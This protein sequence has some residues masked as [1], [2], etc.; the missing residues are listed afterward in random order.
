MQGVALD[1]PLTLLLRLTTDRG[2][3]VSPHLTAPLL[4]AA[5]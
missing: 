5:A 1:Y 3:F 2:R 4:P